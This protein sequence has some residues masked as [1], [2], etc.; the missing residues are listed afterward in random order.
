MSKPR[1]SC[2]GCDSDD[3]DIHTCGKTVRRR[4]EVERPGP[5]AEICEACGKE[6]VLLGDWCE[7]CGIIESRRG[8]KALELLQ[9]WIDWMVKG[10]TQAKFN[11]IVNEARALL[12][13]GER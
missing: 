3:Y 4:A 10:Q 11:D 13:D 6:L 7:Q 1:E 12:K 8:Q 9:R 5:E 2:D